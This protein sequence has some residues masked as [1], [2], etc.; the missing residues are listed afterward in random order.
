MEFEKAKGIITE[1]KN[2]HILNLLN[3]AKE[4]KSVEMKDFYINLCIDF[5]MKD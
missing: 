2:S 3:M 5:L 4:S 1:L